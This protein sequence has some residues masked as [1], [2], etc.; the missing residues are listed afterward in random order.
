METASV[1][2]KQQTREQLLE[3]YKLELALLQT[4]IAQK[5]ILKLAL[6]YRRINNIPYYRINKKVID[7]GV[8]VL[9]RL[10]KHKI[11][12]ID[13]I[14]NGL[15]YLKPT[16]NTE[17]NVEEFKVDAEKY[18]PIYDKTPKYYKKDLITHYTGIAEVNKRNRGVLYKLSNIPFRIT[19]EFSDYPRVPKKGES[20]INNNYILE[21]NLMRKAQKEYNNQDIHFAFQFD[22]RGRVYCKSYLLTTQS[23]EWGKAAINLSTKEKVDYI[24]MLA[25]K[26]DIAVL[27]GLDKESSVVKLQWF[28]ANKDYILKVA[29]E[30]ILDE[31]ADKPILF[32][33]ACKAYKEASEGKPI[34]YMCSIDATASGIQL[35]SLLSRDKSSARLTNLTSEDKRYDIYTHFAN[36]FLDK[37]GRDESKRD[38][39]KARKVL[40][41]CLMTHY[42]NSVEAVRNKLGGN[43]QYYNMFLD[44]ASELCQGPEELL[45]LFNKTYLDNSDKEYL[46]WRMPDGF[47][48]VIEQE[49]DTFYKVNTPYFSCVFK[50]QDIGVDIKSNYRKLAPH[51]IHSIDAWVCREIIR[52]CDFEVSLIHDSFYTHPNN[53]HKVRQV[54]QEILQE[55]NVGKHSNLLEN[56]LSD[57]YGYKVSNPFKDKEP[58]EDIRNSY[59]CLS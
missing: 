31:K 15:V 14:R 29:N 55:I 27:Y 46:C 23:E 11:L 49:K 36:I 45:K 50:Y 40:K 20:S 35:A 59:Y 41:P 34:N 21:T 10:M 9:L 56:I 38:L 52:R 7:E 58:L 44:I 22:K 57:I 8:A 24:G 30:N 37:L 54:Y 42:Y 33:K 53:I 43:E 48:V 17:L 39:A 25:L 3:D 32:L 6:R 47:Q 51:I 2:I 5:Y 13:S 26:K 19:S 16:R 28:E 4:D 12:A 1:D 18:Y